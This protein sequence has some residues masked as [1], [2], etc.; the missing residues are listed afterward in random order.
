MPRL[1]PAPAVATALDVALWFLD[2]ARASDGHLPAQKLQNLLY[3]ACAQ[4]ERENDGRPLIPVVFVAN[5]VTVSDPNLYRLLEEGR[6]RVRTEPVSTFVDTFLADV[7]KR[8]ANCT[9]E[10]LNTVVQRAID[11]ETSAIST[12][13]GEPK[14]GPVAPV[15]ELHTV[16]AA[17]APLHPT[18]R[19]RQVMVAPWR[20]PTAIKKVDK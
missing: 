18:H 14:D 8:Y 15:V 19:G 9:V 20:P 1:S 2:K 13:A 12:A 7:W 5:E 17:P 6:P 11:G 3:L 16:K 10:Y 4:F